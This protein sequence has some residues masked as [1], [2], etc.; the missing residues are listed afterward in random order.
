MDSTSG[1]FTLP[2][3]VFSPLGAKY[4]KNVMIKALGKDVTKQFICLCTSTVHL[5]KVGL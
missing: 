1:L 4:T 2:Y 5:L 3:M